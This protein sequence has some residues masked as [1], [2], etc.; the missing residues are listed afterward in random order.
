MPLEHGGVSRPSP[1]ELG[2][3]RFQTVDEVRG[4]FGVFGGREGILVDPIRCQHVLDTISYHQSLKYT[5]CA[6]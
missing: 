3:C 2:N 1:I 4:E 6:C 5:I